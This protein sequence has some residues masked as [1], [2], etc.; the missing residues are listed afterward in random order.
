MTVAEGE[1]IVAMTLGVITLALVLGVVVKGSTDSGRI[2]SNAYSMQVVEP[3]IVKVALQ[4]RTL[5][6]GV[7]GPAL[8]LEAET[9][10]RCERVSPLVVNSYIVN[11]VFYIDIGAYALKPSPN[12]N[13]ENDFQLAKA[14]VPVAS[15]FDDG[16]NKKDTKILLRDSTNSYRLSRDS[17]AVYLEPLETV[18]AV[19]LIDSFS[20]GEKIVVCLKKSSSIAAPVECRE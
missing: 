9:G 18:N 19:P 7:M 8:L 10:A 14:I 13:C 17:Y 5:S 2:S 11:K 16:G 12:K 4:M 15:I 1:K 3:G 6:D 20:E